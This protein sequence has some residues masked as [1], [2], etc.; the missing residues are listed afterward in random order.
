[1][2]VLTHPVD[3]H[4]KE[5]LKSDTYVC[6]RRKVYLT[7]PDDLHLSTKLFANW[8]VLKHRLLWIIMFWAGAQSSSV[9][10]TW[11]P[12]NQRPCPALHTRT[13]ARAHTHT[14]TSCLKID[15]EFL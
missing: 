4:R 8:F 15:P 11:Q 13:P 5:R 12:G 1:M 6:R 3:W 9:L 10:A 2:A 7:K 14:C